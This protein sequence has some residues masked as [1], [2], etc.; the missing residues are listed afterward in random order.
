MNVDNFMLS[1]IFHNLKGFDSHVNMSY[2]DRNFA[3]S[4][5]QAIQISSEKYTSFQIGSLRFL[6]SMQFLNA[7]LDSLVQSLAKDG[8]Y[9]FQQTQ[10]HFSST[11]KSLTATNI[12]TVETNLWKRNYRRETILI[13]I[14]RKTVSAKTITRVPK[15]MEWIQHAK[16]TSAP[17]SVFDFRRL[18]V[19]RCI[20]KLSSYIT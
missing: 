1:V 12:W 15:G 9:I 14:W 7:S 16:S 4:D 18:T 11:K 8:V 17:W 19:S 2:I 13:S 6:D 20:R 5:I 3:P 10:R